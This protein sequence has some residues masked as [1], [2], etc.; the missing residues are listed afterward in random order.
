MKSKRKNGFTLVELTVVLVI[1]A[2][3]MAI[4]SP[5]LYDTGEQQSFAKMSRMQ[6]PF[7][8]Q[9]NQSS[10]GTAHP[11]SGSSLKMK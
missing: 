7:I 3:I 8:W 10:H 4:A 2:I 6:E 1:F 5:F 11:V 9:L